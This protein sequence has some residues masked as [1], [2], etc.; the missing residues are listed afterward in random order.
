[1]LCIRQT[2]R[3]LRRLERDRL[4]SEVFGLNHHTTSNMSV[5]ILTLL[6]NLA[7]VLLGD[8]GGKKF[9]NKVYI[10]KAYIFELQYCMAVIYY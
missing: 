1:M 5:D 10:C 8:F 3:Y 9:I 2:K 7:V 4:F 6:G